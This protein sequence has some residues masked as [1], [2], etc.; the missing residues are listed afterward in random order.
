MKSDEVLAG[1]RFPVWISRSGFSVHEFPC[2]HGDFAIVDTLV[3]MQLDG[4]D[5]VYRRVIGL[6]GLGSTPRRATA[7]EESL[8]GNPVNELVAEDIGQ[9][10]MTGLEDIPTDLQ[11][12]ASVDPSRPGSSRGQAM[13]E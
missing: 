5:R 4:Q 6:L 8:I 9:A 2:L 3:A 13:H 7:A 10:A 1:V 11:R 12:S